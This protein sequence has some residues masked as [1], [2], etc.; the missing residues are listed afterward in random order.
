MRIRVLRKGKRHESE[1][2]G[3]LLYRMWKRDY[4]MGG[5]LSILRRVE[6]HCGA[7]LAG[8]EYVGGKG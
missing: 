4:K 1:S 7:A 3:F 5:A 8:Q 6:Q 2:D